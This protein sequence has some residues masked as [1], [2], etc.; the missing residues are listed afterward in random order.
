MS[1]LV[2]D[3][4]ALYRYLRKQPGAGIVR[5][6]LSEAR[7]RGDKLQMSSVNWGEVYY[8]IAREVGY[9][10]ADRI[11]DDVEQ[12]PLEI[13]APDKREA[14]SAG[15]LKVG[16]GLPYADCFAAAHAGKTGVVVTADVKDFKKVPWVKTLA[17][18]SGKPS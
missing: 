2:L 17:L 16:Y 11:A 1:R 7:A 18:P 10:E 3:S 13:V 12:L 15:R 14:E 9:R 6:L 4:N 8:T 5:N